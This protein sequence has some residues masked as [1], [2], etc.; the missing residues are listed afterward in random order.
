MLDQ[1]SQLLHLKNQEGDIIYEN[2]FEDDEV[3]SEEDSSLVDTGFAL[4][5]F[6]VQMLVLMI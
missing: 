2:K 3:Y 6:M 1:N 4:S 5:D